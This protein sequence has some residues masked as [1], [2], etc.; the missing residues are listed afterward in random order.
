MASFG[1]LSA[2]LKDLVLIGPKLAGMF[3]FDIFLVCSML[4][5]PLRSNA[6][7][8]QI[9]GYLKTLTGTLSSPSAYLL[10]PNTSIFVNRWQ[11]SEPHRTSL[12]V[13]LPKVQTVR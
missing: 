13:N 9:G 5:V 6:Y 2:C 4:R 12:F 3:V 8:E 1:F 11:P 7:V 10:P